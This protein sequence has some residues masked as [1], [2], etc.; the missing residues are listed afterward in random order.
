MLRQRRQLTVMVC[1][2]LNATELSV[3]FDPEDVRSIMGVFRTRVHEAV[4]KFGGAIAQQHDDGIVAYF[5][6]STLP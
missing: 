5:R 1:R 4:R 2:V 6:P 3:A